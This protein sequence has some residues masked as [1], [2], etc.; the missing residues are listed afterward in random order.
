[1]N[2]VNDLKTIS[3]QI[4]KLNQYDFKSL[5]SYREVN[6]LRKKLLDDFGMYA[7]GNKIFPNKISRNFSISPGTFNVEITL[8]N[9]E[10]FYD[11]IIVRDDPIKN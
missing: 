1:M 5:T 10:K 7:N 3:G 9:G 2:I 6:N 8:K 4:D 11:T